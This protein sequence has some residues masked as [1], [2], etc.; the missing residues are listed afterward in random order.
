MQGKYELG[1]SLLELMIVVAIV[2]ILASIAY[3]SYQEQVADGRRVDAQANILSLA[4]HMEREYTENGTYVGAALPYNEAPKDG[5]D[6]FY[7]LA[8][9]VQT[10][11]TYILRARPKNGMAG[12]R[13]GDMTVNHL[14]Q[15]SASENDCW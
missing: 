4:Q 1:F 8:L 2:G 10:A 13:C 12:D 3:P 6:K 5:A 14:G 11:T 15:K 7:D 9:P